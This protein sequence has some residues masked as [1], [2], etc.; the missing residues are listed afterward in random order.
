MWI[1]QDFIDPMTT[2]LPRGVAMRIL[3][4]VINILLGAIGTVEVIIGTL[5]FFVWLMT[6]VRCRLL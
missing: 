3:L 2:L 4:S 1:A 5:G 6:Y